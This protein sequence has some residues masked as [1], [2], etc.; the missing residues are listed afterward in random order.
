MTG[1]MFTSICR[2]DLKLDLPMMIVSASLELKRAAR[3]CGADAFAVKS[4][5]LRDIAEL[6]RGILKK[7]APSSPIT[8]TVDA[9]DNI[10]LREDMRV[11]RVSALDDDAD[12]SLVCVSFVTTPATALGPHTE[13][14][15][16]ESESESDLSAV[17]IGSGGKIR[18]PDKRSPTAPTSYPSGEDGEEAFEANKELT[19]FPNRTRAATTTQQHAFLVTG[20]VG[21]SSKR[22]SWIPSEKWAGDEYEVASFQAQ[23]LQLH[24]ITGGILLLT[25]HSLHF[26]VT[27]S[28]SE[29]SLSIPQVASEGQDESVERTTSY[30][31]GLTDVIPSSEPSANPTVSYLHWPLDKI[32]GMYSR[33]HLIQTSGIE[34]YFGDFSSEVY[35]LFKSS[36]EA[37]SFFKQITKQSLPMLATSPTTLSPK[38]V[39]SALNWTDLWRRR[40]ISNFEYLMRLNI[41]AGFNFLFISKFPLRRIIFSLHY[42][43]EII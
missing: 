34:I 29:L 15:Y 22:P 33:K 6:L 43:R 14:G 11:V 8:R 12:V 40:L 25:S 1:I 32:I 21:S 26:Q 3:Q 28:L 38:V 27:A 10:M 5:P 23:R 30:Y 18:S 37:D 16:T 31:C 9:T 19:V 36:G 4:A 20:G 7:D 13:S 42:L 35:F 17:N 24:S 41:L 2:A 39:I